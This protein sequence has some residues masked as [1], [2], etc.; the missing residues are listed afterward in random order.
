M[1]SQYPYPLQVVSNSA[2]SVQDANGNFIK[3]EN[4]TMPIVSRCRDEHNSNYAI[5]LTVDGR[6]FNYN[7]AIQLPKTCPD[8]QIGDYVKVLT[9]CGKAVRCEGQIQLFK[10][11]QMHCRAYI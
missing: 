8:L 3:D 5:S 6:T 11:D 10:R 2:E 4:I 7:Y 9:I 1:V